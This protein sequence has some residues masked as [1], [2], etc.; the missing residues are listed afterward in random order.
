MI[1]AEPCTP[2]SAC[3]LLLIRIWTA[4]L[5]REIIKKIQINGGGG[6]NRRGNSHTSITVTGRITTTVPLHMD[7]YIN[8]EFLYSF[9]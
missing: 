2:A 7:P 5:F 1:E 8:T 9:K 3:Q 4:V 6:D